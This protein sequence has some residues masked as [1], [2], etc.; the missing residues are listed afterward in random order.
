MRISRIY[1]NNVALTVNH[2]GQEAVVIGRGIAF[3]K[4]K[5]QM[6]D[7][8]AVEQTFVPEQGMSGERLSLTLS[9]IPAEI[10]SIATGLESRVRADGVLELSNSFIIPLAD[11]LHYAV[12]RAR[13]GVRVDYPLAPE[14]T[15]LY[16]REVEYGRSVIAAVRERLQVQMDPGEAI[17]L[18]LHLVNAQFATADMSQAFRM[19]E[20]FAQVFEII[21]ASYEQKID[22]DSMSAARFVTHLRYLFVRASR[23]SANRAED[24]DEVSQPSLLAALRADA[25]RAYACA[26]KVLLVLQMQLKQSLTRDELT[27]LTIHIARLARDMWG[28]N[29]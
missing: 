26:Q 12:M 2:L 20:V 29:A 18:A 19:T 21:E 14:V 16:P 23:A 4:R 27:Y 17:P 10:L 8:A 7:P 24:V 28:I 22:P 15:L 5:G 25:P 9:E 1:N 13:E 11:H 3:G 6:I